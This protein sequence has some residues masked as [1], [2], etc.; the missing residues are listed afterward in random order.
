[1]ITLPKALSALLPELIF[2][3]QQ[4]YNVTK[5]YISKRTFQSAK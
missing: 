1:M 4:K 5:S 3:N 2:Y